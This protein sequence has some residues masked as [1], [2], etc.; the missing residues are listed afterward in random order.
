[1]TQNKATIAQ[2]AQ[3]VK[4][5]EK[6]N[7]RDQHYLEDQHNIPKEK[8]NNNTATVK[9]NTDTDNT[10]NEEVDQNVQKDLDRAEVQDPGGAKATEKEKEGHTAQLQ[11]PKL[12][13]KDQHQKRIWQDQSLSRKDNHNQGIQHTTNWNKK[14][15]NYGEEQTSYHTVHNTTDHMDATVHAEWHTYRTGNIYR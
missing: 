6:V 4:A 2:E 10:V 3:I 12:R 9:D 7:T 8:E 13:R 1:M 5:K 11:Q 15:K 14:T